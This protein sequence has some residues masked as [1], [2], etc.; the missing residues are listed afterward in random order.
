[1]TQL[2]WLEWRLTDEELPD[3]FAMVDSVYPEMASVVDL[4][5]AADSSVDPQMFAREIAE[6]IAVTLTGEFERVRGDRTPP[7]P[8]E[9]SSFMR[10]I[11]RPRDSRP[12]TLDRKTEPRQDSGAFAV[13]D[14]STTVRSMPK[15]TPPGFEIDRDIAA[16]FARP[17]S[18][19]DPTVEVDL[20]DLTRATRRLK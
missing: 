20:S 18:E 15:D 3:L 14:T 6:N 19:E 9:T 7:F 5:D 1:M 11:P 13:P 16:M 4:T 2:G 12:L 8:V 17:A 10:E